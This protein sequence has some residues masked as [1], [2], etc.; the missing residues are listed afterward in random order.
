VCDPLHVSIG[1]QHGIIRECSEKISLP[2]ILLV[3][4]ECIFLFYL[5]VVIEEIIDTP[6]PAKAD[7]ATCGYHTGAL[8]ASVNVGSHLVVTVKIGTMVRVFGKK[9]SAIKTVHVGLQILGRGKI[10]HIRDGILRV[11]IKEILVT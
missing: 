9:S 10:V 5:F 2:K 1:L 4:L 7:T 11:T 6:D 3:V 8:K